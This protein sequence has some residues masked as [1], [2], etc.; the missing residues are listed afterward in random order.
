MALLSTGVAN[1]SVVNLK[2]VDNWSSKS[3]RV[4]RD[5][6]EILE[7]YVT[8]Q[9]DHVTYI[10]MPHKK[11]WKKQWMIDFLRKYLVDIMGNVGLFSEV[12]VL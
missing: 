4:Y 11:T 5:R 6:L 1:Y 3:S 9:R 2:D 10:Q 8:L 7:N 12:L